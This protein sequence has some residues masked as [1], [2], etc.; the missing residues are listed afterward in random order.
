MLLAGPAWAQDLKIVAGK[1]AGI[2]WTLWTFRAFAVVALGSA[3]AMVFSRNPV[4]AALFLVVTLFCTGGIYLTLHATFLAAI[5]VL[6]YAGAIMVL[7]IFVVMSVGHPEHEELGLT[8]GLLSKAMAIVAAA[9]LFFRVAPMLK[10]AVV[11]DPAP[12]GES[13]GTVTYVGK[14][15]FSEYLFPFEAISLLLLV[16]IVGAVMITRRRPRPVSAEGQK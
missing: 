13:F 4:V 8:K 16:A 3:V 10:N 2:D 1:T 15:L 7:F 12:V 5:Q 9:I 6:V 14:L 11:Q